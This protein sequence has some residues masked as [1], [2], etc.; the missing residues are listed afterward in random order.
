MSYTYKSLVIVWLI[1]FG[2]LALTTSGVVAGSWFVLLVAAGLAAPALM[3]R[4]PARA[5][6]I[7]PQSH[8]ATAHAR[9]DSL[10]EGGAIDLYRWENEGGRP[11]EARQRWIFG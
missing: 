11:A 7:S 2:L 10:L 1:A 3:L 9:A 4:S 5:T 8:R 6:A